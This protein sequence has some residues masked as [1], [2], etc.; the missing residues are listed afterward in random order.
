MRKFTVT[1][2]V[3]ASLRGKEAALSLHQAGR[4]LGLSAPLC[5]TGVLTVPTS[6]RRTQHI[7]RAQ[8]PV[9]LLL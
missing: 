7:L 9:D 4:T 8:E 5:K 1:E 3:M 2:S 6:W